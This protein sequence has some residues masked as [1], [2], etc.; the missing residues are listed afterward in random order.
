[1]ETRTTYGV[2]LK[3]RPSLLASALSKLTD[4]AM[5]GSGDAAGN[6][7]VLCVSRPRALGG[8]GFIVLILR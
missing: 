6:E 3:G 7:A 8:T 2:V 4:I 1:M 5:G